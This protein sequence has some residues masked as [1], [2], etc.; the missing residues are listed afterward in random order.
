MEDEPMLQMQQQ[1]SITDIARN[2]LSQLRDAIWALDKNSLTLAQW[3]SRSNQYLKQLQSNETSIETEFDWPET[4]SLSPVK[5]LHSFRIL[6]EACANAI[7]H[8]KP[9]T[10]LVNGFANQQYLVLV[11][12]DNGQG[13]DMSDI[14]YGYGLKNMMKRAGEMGG[15]L[16]VSSMRDAGTT[17]TLRWLIA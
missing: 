13:F 15:T 4:L 5:A 11:V 3:M 7:K 2:T 6:Q 1:V 10:I 8:A 9:A 17:I 14:K 16:E 12:Q